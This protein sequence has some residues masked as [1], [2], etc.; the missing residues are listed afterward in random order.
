MKNTDQRAV[1]YG[2]VHTSRGRTEYVR[3]GSVVAM[4]TNAIYGAVHVCVVMFSRVNLSVRVCSMYHVYRKDV[5][6]HV[7]PRRLRN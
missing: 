5:K 2:G 6:C 1:G 3:Y 7:V 4:Y